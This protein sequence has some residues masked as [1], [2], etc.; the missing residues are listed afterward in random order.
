MSGI[1]HTPNSLLHSWH[2]HSTGCKG[3]ATAVTRSFS[4]VTGDNV[5]LPIYEALLDCHGS[6]CDRYQ[7]HYNKYYNCSLPSAMHITACR[8][9][10]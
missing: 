7:L 4:V 8:G 5:A 2:N 9:F 1:H 6:L 10:M 3:L